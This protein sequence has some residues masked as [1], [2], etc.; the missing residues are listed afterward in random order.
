M[1]GIVFLRL[2]SLEMPY[3]QKEK[4]LGKIPVPFYLTNYARA[5]AGKSLAVTGQNHACMEAIF[6]LHH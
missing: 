3:P 4:L 1:A 6:S 5:Q 2:N